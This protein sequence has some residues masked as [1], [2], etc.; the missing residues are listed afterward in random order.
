M[1]TPQRPF[2]I[3]ISALGGE[4]GGVL[5]GWIVDA[6]TAQ[7]YPVQNTSIP[8][9]AQRTGA[10][11][12]Y[13]EIFPVPREQLG[14]RQP[15]FAHQGTRVGVTAKPARTR[16]GKGGRGQGH[17]ALLQRD[18]TVA[19]RAGNPLAG[20]GRALLKWSADDSPWVVVPCFPP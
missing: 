15:V 16:G 13:I 6:A 10:T 19:R 1:N 7:G 9:L 4:G 18:A 5:A 2:T 20:P 14:G 17:G 11:T 3:L 8:G 12:Y